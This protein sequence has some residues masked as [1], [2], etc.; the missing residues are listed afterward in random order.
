MGLLT[1]HK[2]PHVSHS[3]YWRHIYRALRNRG[4]QHPLDTQRPCQGRQLVRQHQ[5]QPSRQ[6]PARLCPV[7]IASLRPSKQRYPVQHSQLTRQ[8]FARP[9]CRQDCQLYRAGCCCYE[10]SLR[11]WG[12]YN[13]RQGAKEGMQRKCTQDS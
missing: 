2:L 4:Q 12:K 9:K 1:S 13:E 7:I 6:C 10:G 11:T 3:F 5:A 8:V